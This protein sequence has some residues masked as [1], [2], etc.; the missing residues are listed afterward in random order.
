MKHGIGR[1]VYKNK[2]EYYGYMENDKRH[3]EGVMTYANKDY[4]SGIFS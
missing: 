1:M 3:G 2:E 4:Y